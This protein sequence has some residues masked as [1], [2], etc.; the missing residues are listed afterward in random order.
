MRGDP[1]K[2]NA[3]KAARFNS[4][5]FYAIVLC[6]LALLCNSSGCFANSRFRV[7][8]ID[9]RFQL[10]RYKQEVPSSLGDEFLEPLNSHVLDLLP[11]GRAGSRCHKYGGW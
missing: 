3:Q 1:H 2:R 7:P 4:Q 9:S 10:G 11:A 6:G 5:D 8:S